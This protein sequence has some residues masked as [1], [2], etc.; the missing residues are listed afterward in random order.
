MHFLFTNSGRFSMSAAFKW[1]NWE[2]YLLELTVWFSRRSSLIEDSLPI[3]PYTHHLL[4]MKTSLWC[5]WWWFISLA[6][7]SLPFHIIVQYPLFI[8]I[9]ICFKNGTFSLRLS[10][11]SHEEIWSGRFFSLNLRRTQTSKRLT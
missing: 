11:E 5:G 10:R 3:P 4:W 9:T 7:R 1:S 2:Q 8:A 6:P